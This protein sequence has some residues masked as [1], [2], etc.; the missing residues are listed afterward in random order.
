MNSTFVYDREYWL[1]QSSSSPMYLV[2]VLPS[3]SVSV[4][5]PLT[6]PFCTMVPLDLDNPSVNDDEALDAEEG[7]PPPD[8]KCRLLYRKLKIYIQLVLVF[9]R[10][11][12]RETT[13]F[14]IDLT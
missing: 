3:R 10:E 2:L 5:N 7:N 8:R 11:T 12:L 1:D 4:T 9:P 14:V 6:L 13:L